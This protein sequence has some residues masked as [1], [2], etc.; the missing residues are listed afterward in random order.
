M[1]N[2][3]ERMKVLL[4]IKN[5]EEIFGKLKAGDLSPIDEFPDIDEDDK[6]S[7]K[8]MSWNDIEIN[9]EE[10]DIDNFRNL[11]DIGVEFAANKIVKTTIRE[12]L[13]W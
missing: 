1:S 8:R 7:L 3:V 9:I 4:F 5:N 6:A 12:F 10:N 13:W 2:P 11:G